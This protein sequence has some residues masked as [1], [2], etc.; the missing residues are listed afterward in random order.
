M[1]TVYVYVRIMCYL[2]LLLWVLSSFV[3]IIPNSKAFSQLTKHSLANVALFR[4]FIIC[5]YPHINNRIGAQLWLEK[6]KLK[7]KSKSTIHAIFS[8]LS[9]F[10]L[11]MYIH[12]WH[13]EYSESVWLAIPFS[14]K[15]P[16]CQSIGSM[17]NWN[18]NADQWNLTNSQMSSHEITTFKWIEFQFLLSILRMNGTICAEEKWQGNATIESHLEMLIQLY[19]I[20][21][22]DILLSTAFPF[23]FFFLAPYLFLSRIGEFPVRIDDVNVHSISMILETWL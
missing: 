11:I 7:Q 9:S 10:H 3:H 5:Y 14:S 13:I 16:R 2:F 22:S 8:L 12:R 18:Q 19:S 21:D 6:L 23:F 15:N 4:M 20:M 17:P 1:K